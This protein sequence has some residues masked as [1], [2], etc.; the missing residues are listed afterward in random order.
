MWFAGVHADIGG[1]YPEKESGL[2]KFPLIW[3]I[4][5]AVKCGLTVDRRTINQLR[6]G[7][8]RGK[9]ARSATS[10]PISCE[11]PHN[12]MSAA[13]RALEFIPKA[14]KYKEWKERKS[15]L[16][17]YIP[18]AEPRPIAEDAFIHES[19]VQRMNAVSKYRPV[20]FPSRYQT[21][22]MVPGPSE[23]G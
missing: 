5:E 17:H 15:F 19:V 13:W 10:L 23:H 21:I 22:P 1:G 7:A 18:D 3:M 12:S 9:T 6:H 4:E 20:N 11:N 2:S 16:G 8:N 14:D